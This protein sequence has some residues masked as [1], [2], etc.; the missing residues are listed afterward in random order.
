MTKNYHRDTSVTAL[1]QDLGWP[2]LARRRV[3]RDCTMWYKIHYGLVRLPFPPSVVLKP[4]LAKDDHS[5]AYL[6]LNTRVNC[7]QFT[8]FARTIILWEGLMAHAVV[9]PSL[10][11]FL[12]LVSAQ[13]LG[14]G[15]P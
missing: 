3:L 7:Y 11:V 8:Y 9:A 15:L 10:E 12:S 6:Q 13:I 4:R 14:S 2:D 1:K 5:L